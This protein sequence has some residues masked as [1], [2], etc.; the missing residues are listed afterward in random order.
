MDIFTFL[1]PVTYWILIILWSFILAFY[2]KRLR[3]RSQQSQLIFTLLIILAIDAF[4]TLFESLYFGAWYTA[5][6]GFLPIQV[7]SFLIR[8]EMV[9]IPKIL[10]VIAAVIVI[11][12][13][14]YRW[15]PQ[16]EMEKENLKKLIEKN[17]L[18]LTK[19]NET[20]RENEERYRTILQTAMNGFWLTDIKGNFLEVNDAYAQMIGYS[21]EELL[22]MQISDIEAN[23]NPEKTNEHI[24]KVIKTGIDRFETVHRRKDFSTCDVEVNS[25]YIPI[26]GGRLVV[27]TRDITE[28]KQAEAALRGSEEKY[29][30]LVE[31]Q[32][33][34]ICRF[35]SDGTFLFVND[36]YAEFFN[37][38]KKELVGSKWHPLPVDDDVHLI[39]AELSKLTPDNPTVTIENRVFSGEGEIHWMQFVNKGIFDLDG[40]LMEIQSVGRDIT[41]RKLSEKGLQEIECIVST[42]SDMMALLNKDF[43]YLSAND[44][45]VN[46]FGKT[47]DEIIGYSVSDI[48][49]DEFFEKIIKPNAE[50]CLSGQEV[51]YNDWFE[52]PVG[53]RQCMDIIYTPYWGDNKKIEGFVVN[54]RNITELKQAEVENSRLEDRLR[55]AQKMESIG[56]LAG[57]VAHDYNN[58]LTAIT[59]Y[60]ELALMDADPNGSLRADLKEI[61][62]ASRHAKDITRQLLA[63]A[64]KQ[65]IAPIVLD[66]NTGIESMFKMLRRLIGEDIDL[67][68]FPGENLWPV[69]MDPTQI[70][71][72]LA[73][74]CINAKDAIA[75]VGK[76]TIET[77]Q[78][79][80]DEAYCADHRGFIPGEFVLMAISDNGCGMDKEIIDNIFEPFFTTKDIN[81]G[82]GLGLSTVYGIVKQNKGFIS[83]YSEPDKGTTIK[84]YLPRHEGKAIEPK[85]ESKEEIPQ[86][87]GETILL[88]EDETSILKL[89]QKILNGLDY[90][91]LAANSPKRAL[92]LAK[93]HNSEIHL[94]V[95]DVIM[96]EMNGLEL[97]NS[98]QSLYPDLKRIF[99]SGYTANAIAHHGVLDKGIDFI[100]KPF[101]RTDLAKIVRKVLD[102]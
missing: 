6:V 32:T 75:G 2:I 87:N 85:K 78:I 102:E 72:I 4:R 67:A 14:L 43:V 69:K 61:L 34:L 86:G 77:S 100:Q 89:A 26:E 95:T 70:D 25:R 33:D 1:T 93:E 73:N 9:F 3:L 94:L 59:G 76:V 39:E 19:S 11:A 58:A 91:V 48:F 57:G 56:R 13:L 20:L 37:K 42:S 53:G 15:L 47:K 10:N 28:S 45:Y 97:A 38:P 40:N 64:R 79:E 12:L 99:M 30:L 23:K 65:T 35:S 88:V 84:I 80:L 31:S 22:S 24:Q 8:P 44:S 46:T 18:E 17:T 90:K 71:Q 92:K 36:V 101:S 55:Q 21:I 51:H 96:P 52:F 66:L 7:H 62:K 74:L 98:L 41:E 27:F 49:G 83:V 16:E 54:A 82:T 81:K 50:H 68:W 5:L 60:T 29:R 63:F